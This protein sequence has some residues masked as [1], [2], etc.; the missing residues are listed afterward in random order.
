M[1]IRRQIRDPLDLKTTSIRNTDMITRPSACVNTLVL[2]PE[3]E[4]TRARRIRKGRPSAMAK[5]AR[6][7]RDI[8]V[9]P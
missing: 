8:G 4:E 9:I 5:T 1:R 6:T 3:A 2:T 7:D